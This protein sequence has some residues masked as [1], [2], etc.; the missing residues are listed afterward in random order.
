MGVAQIIR[1]KRDVTF[2]CVACLLYLIPPA[3]LIWG[4][5][6]FVAGIMGFCLGALVAMIPFKELVCSYCSHSLLEKTSAR[7]LKWYSLSIPD[8]CPNCN[9]D[10]T[11]E[12]DPANLPLNSGYGAL[13]Q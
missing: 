7:G 1:L 8:V 10:L 13:H 9:R 2:V 12:Y 11:R 3:N 5:S 4:Q 6:G